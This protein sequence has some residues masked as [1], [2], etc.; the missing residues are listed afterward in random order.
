MPSRN[1]RPGTSTLDYGTISTEDSIRG[2]YASTDVQGGLTSPQPALISSTREEIND[3]EESENLGLQARPPRFR[4]TRDGLKRNTGLL[5]IISS[6]VFFAMMDA[7]VKELHTIDPPVGTLQLLAVRM[8]FTYMCSMIYMVSAGIPDAFFG[9]KGVRLLLMSR[10]IGGFFG[11]FGIYYS[12]QYLSLSDATVLTFLSPM[13]TAIAASFLLG[14]VFTIKEALAGMI[15]LVGVVLIARPTFIFGEASH[16]AGKEVTSAERLGAV[17]L[18]LVGVLGATTAYISIRAIGK[19]AHP[20]HNMV[21]LS[22][23]CVVICTIAMIATKTELVIPTRLDWLALLLMIG[24]FG[25]I[26]QL[27]LTMGL[28]RETAGRGTMVLYT[29]IIFASILEHIFFHTNPTIL[30]LFSTVLIIGSALYV[31]VS[32]HSL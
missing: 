19:R 22:A 11:V 14:E 5:L 2:R 32:S 23:Q 30:S 7:G 16:P 1:T 4:R 25:F 28:Q 26:A 15:S 12:L 17:G 6:Q 24:I 8:V 3:L 13:C 9:P 27:L 29:Q 18:S 10:G 21:Y 31:A 20:M